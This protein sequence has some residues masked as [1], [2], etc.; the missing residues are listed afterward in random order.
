MIIV[1]DGPAGTGK[2]TVAKN[3]AKV[4]GFTFFDTG[5]MY[6]SL[7]WM[8]Q[9]EN[10]DSARPEVIARLLPRFA[11][12]VQ[13][14]AS[15]EKRYFVCKTDVTQA[16][17][18][19]E[20][21]AI[22]SRI[23]IYPEVRNA[24]VRIQRQLALGRNAVFEGRDMGTVVFPDADLKFFLTAKPEVRAQRRLL[25]LKGRFP[26]KDFQLDHILK[27]M[28]ERDRNDS[29]RSIAPLKRAKD[30]HLID[31]SEKT[32]DGVTEEI[33]HFVPQKNR[34]ARKKWLYAAVYW[35]AR[36]FFKVCFGLKIYG[37]NHF[38]PGAGIIVA[39]HASN[40][41]PP[42]LSISCPE[43]VHFLAKESLFNIPL[44]GR[45]IR[46]LN[47]HPVS[48]SVTDA[49][50]FRSLI[51][52]LQAG[53]KVILF[54]EGGRSQDGRMQPLQRG[55]AFLVQKGGCPIFPAYI[56]GTY[57]AWPIQRKFP[58]LFGKISV[59]FGPPIEWSEFEGLNK[60]EA[61]QKLNERTMQALND[62]Q[63]MS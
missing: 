60:K 27:E 31:T 59:A 20:I 25:E 62:L 55:L 38:R 29:T 21:S 58:K 47:A 14:D 30:A 9:Q 61:E 50:T 12:E 13:A 56:R 3:V 39:N 33:L 54:P 40:Y 53:K 43:E 24:M 22:A 51:V 7:A 34:Y 49:S 52:L 15:E 8:I 5:A 48:R 4:L 11:F 41:D 46:L 57:E 1:I 32:I 63:L 37:L 42:V 2:S 28:Q 19:P 23:A 6:R 10:I 35:T 17:R 45:I 36:A 18:E 44:L 26:D 16:I